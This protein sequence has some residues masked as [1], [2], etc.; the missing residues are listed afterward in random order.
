M[1]PR[2]AIGLG[3]VSAAWVLSVGFDLLLHAGLLARLYVQP[4][5]FLLDPDAA[6]RR[7]PAGYLSFLVITLAVAWLV[8]R[9]DVR[10][11][12]AGFRLGAT[13]GLVAWGAFLLGLWSISTARPALLAGWWLG[14][15]V[16]TGLAGAVCGA[17]AGGMPMP[18]LWRRVGLAVA[19]CVALTVLLQ[20][21]GFAPAMR[22]ESNRIVS[23]RR[24]PN[25]MGMR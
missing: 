6:F 23:A 1:Q 17:A 15:S 2:A 16:E 21:L 12:G 10:G 3:A 19:A 25:R 18:R 13:A 4:G 8:R 24:A 22:V 20:S 14:Q 7:I 9:L 5:P 11:A